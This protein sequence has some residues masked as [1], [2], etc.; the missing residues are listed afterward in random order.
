MM[1]P[2]AGELPRAY[3]N[4]DS[5]VIFAANLKTDDGKTFPIAVVFKG[6][7]PQ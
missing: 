3:T 7:A 1:G 5:Y 4:A 2:E 6:Q